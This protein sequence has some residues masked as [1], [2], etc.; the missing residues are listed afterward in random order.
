MPELQLKYKASR[1]KEE[2]TVYRGKKGIKTI[3]E[4]ILKE[5]KDL[6]AYGAES[7]FKTLFPYYQKHWNSRRAKQGIKLNIIWS[8]RVRKT[9]L[10]EKFKLTNKRFLPRSYEFPSSVVIYGDRVVTFVWAEVP[11][12]FMIKSKEATKSNMGFFRLLWNQAS[13]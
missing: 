3:F 7:R 2:A 6:Y 1:A 9:K 4:D 10:K 11:F 12:G 8:E 5:N 13:K